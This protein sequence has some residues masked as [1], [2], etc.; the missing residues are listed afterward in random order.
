MLVCPNCRKGK[1]ESEW[2]N[3]MSPICDECRLKLEKEEIKK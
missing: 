1:F 2:T 3:C